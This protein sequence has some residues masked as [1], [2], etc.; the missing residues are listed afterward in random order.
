METMALRD[1]RRRRG[2]RS[3]PTALVI[4][5]DEPTRAVVMDRFFRAA[6]FQTTVVHHPGQVVAAV[7]NA[8]DNTG[9]AAVVC[10]FE[11]GGDG[12]NLQVLDQIRTH[13]DASVAAARVVMVAERPN[14]AFAYSNATDGYLARPVHI[15]ALVREVTEA[16][17]RPEAERVAHRRSAARAALGAA[18]NPA[19]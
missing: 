2:S 5:S 8:C 17:A 19:A 4:G 13:T 6:G 15:K 18:D 1:P 14:P 10:D 11:R 9:G 12:I 3:T 7:V 16:V